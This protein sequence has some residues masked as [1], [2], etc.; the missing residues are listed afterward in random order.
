MTNNKDEQLMEEIEEELSPEETDVIIDQPIE[1]SVEASIISGVPQNLFSQLT[2]K[3]QNFIV[4]VDKQ[5]G[6]KISLTIKERI[7]L[8]I[9][10]TLIEG[11]ASSQTAKQL[12]GTPSETVATILAQ[13]YSEDDTEVV[14]SPDWQIALDGG[15]MLG[16]IYTL[17]TGISML[18]ADPGQVSRFMGIT[19]L[20][21]N[22]IVAGYAMLITS[23]VIPN[24]DAKKGERKIGRYLLI[25]TLAM[26]GWIFLV[27]LSSVILPAAINPV[28]SG[29]IYIIIGAITLL[30]KFILKRQLNIR[31][32]IF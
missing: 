14:R 32:G 31:G 18:N 24:F 12:Y 26:I 4:S 11:Q 5:L 27:S 25:S 30:L 23:R 13:E 15:L 16:S 1:T 28:F 6:E 9:V 17:I 3:N 7:N 10:E 21:I 2:S 8:E 22:Y 29:Q 20:I 19:T